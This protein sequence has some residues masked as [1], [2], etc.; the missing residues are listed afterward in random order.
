M[1]SARFILAKRCPIAGTPRPEN[2]AFSI[3]AP[4]LFVRLW[5]PLDGECSERGWFQTSRFRK[6]RYTGSDHQA[7]SPEIWC[8]REASLA[9]AQKVVCPVGVGTRI[10][11]AGPRHCAITL[12]NRT[13]SSIPGTILAGLRA[14]F[15]TT[16]LRRSR[17]PDHRR[18][19]TLTR[20]SWEVSW[21][22][23]GL[24]FN[25]NFFLR[26]NFSGWIGRKNC[27]QTCEDD[28]GQLNGPSLRWILAYL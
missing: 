13:A 21:I 3:L 9:S 12:R 25:R 4:I 27:E 26:E 14:H 20:P 6:E 2:M 15:T 23:M 5:N 8:P 16:A 17:S 10:R 7:T 24:A 19:G 22:T 28:S 1:M 11:G 18:D